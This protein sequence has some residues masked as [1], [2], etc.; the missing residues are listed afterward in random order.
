[1]L[2][3]FLFRLPRPLFLSDLP[4]LLRLLLLDHAWR[5]WRPA[6][7]LGLCGCGVGRR[8]LFFFFLFFL[9]SFCWLFTPGS[10]RGGES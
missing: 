1:M 9:L 10:W 7:N 5:W 6:G 2:N 4:A 8:H 3:F